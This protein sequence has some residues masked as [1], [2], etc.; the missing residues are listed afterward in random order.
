[1]SVTNTSP[2]SAKIALFRSLFHGRVEVYPR[3]FESTKSGK[4][5]Y[6]PVCGNEW[7]RGICEKPRIKCGDCAHQRWL[8]VTD[9]VVRMHLSGAD[10]RGREFVAGVYPMLLD[11]RC[12]FLA[13]DFDEGDWSSDALAYLDTCRSLQIDA[14]LE[15]SRSGNGGHVW[16]FF[17]EAIPATLA[18]KLGAHVLTETMERRP[19]A[20]FKSYDRFF[21]N[22]DTLP[23]GGF[24]N[25][26]AL[27]LQKAAREK[28]NSVF[29][30]AALQPH[31]DQW[32]FL[33]GI[34]RVSKQCVEAI[35]REAEGRG[36]IVGVRMAL[37]DD[38]DAAEP[39]KLTPSRRRDALPSGAMP[40]ALEL[41]LSDQVYVPKR[42]LP[43]SLRNAL[44]RLAAFQNPE[45]YKTQAMRLPT[46][47]KPRIIACADDHAEHIALPRG[48][49]DEALDLLR[50]LKI[51]VKLRDERFAGR[52]LDVK[53]AGTL[54]PDQ[55][56]AGAA[57]MA[58]DF[59]VLAATT[60]FGKTV[61]AAW[62][63]A[64]RDVNTL[65]L[66]HRQQLME[67]WV[68]RLSQ[69]LGVTPKE[70]G[71]WGGGRKKLT[72]RIDVA[73][74]QS[75]VRKGEVKDLVADYGHLVVD[76]CHHLS[77]HS[78]ELVARRAKA[79]FVTGL[80]AT[81]A[82]KDGHHPIIF[83]QCGPVRHR[84]DA[85]QQALERPFTHEVLVRPTGFF[86]D[87]DADEDKRV[88]YQRLC[89]AV[90]NSASRNQLIVAEI[91][92][93]VKAG[94][95]PVV[96]T[97]RT[98]HLEMIA[99]QLRPYVTHVVTLQGGM[100]RKSLNAALELLKTI[101]TTESRVMIATGRFIGE[102]FDDSRL[103]TL[104]LT[105]PV[106]WRGTIAQYVGRLHRL[107]DGKRVVQ[108]YDYA[109]LDVPMLARMFDKRCAG[110]EA[111]GYT[112][113]LPAS[114]LP[115][116]PVEVPLPIDPQWKQDYAASVKRLIRDG[117][118]QPLAQLFVHATHSHSA[119]AEGADR[120]RSA[121]EAFIFRR[122]E[123]LPE[124]KNRFRLNALLPIA[125]D[126]RG[127]MEVDLLCEE[128]K[129]V[130][131]IDGAQH[132][133]DAEAYRRDRRKDALLQA[134]GYFVL[135]FL[136]D[137]LGKHLDVILD[138]VLRTLAR[139]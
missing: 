49:L 21:P 66:V 29:V 4:S 108:V 47:D 14:A 115:G 17:E 76:E 11:E 27:P 8:P 25:L 111:V 2:P 40:A 96:L 80:S 60:A 113:L 32:A 116:W 19:E 69:F 121:S 117:V 20:G 59:G 86:P 3:R 102:G 126:D 100:G 72:G 78:F 103:D 83:M 65:I 53:F 97:E 12:F 50:T 135:R 16:I 74:M 23:R 130:I 128:A 75:L 6:S 119:D 33:S 95:S 52:A 89:N 131:E 109:D 54:R 114:A 70:I 48:C 58:H 63:I 87:G 123:T 26:I 46:Y 79:K 82:R 106:S 18:R 127:Q 122:F 55:A 37:P 112:I 93:A 22:Q 31:E 85:R 71:R 129:L 42:E 90:M 35:V 136:A 56:K 34:K 120:A 133:G 91:V 73:L 13:V 39:W 77:A 24:G 118:D 139:G 92:Q 38:E 125:F 36:R 41:V 138:T 110:Y 68:E 43:P 105:M 104:F 44:V 64:Q 9:E 84:V 5:G 51:K 98:E 134:H 124:L 57:M 28:G 61:L 30:D 7:V 101:P 15:R 81:V 1:M 10:E 132:L 67:Q 88:E 107:H 137:D 94:R 62:L 99:S 45:F